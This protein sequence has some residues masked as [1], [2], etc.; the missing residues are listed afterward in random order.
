MKTSAIKNLALAV[1]GTS[2]I[3]VAPIA[4]AADWHRHDV[5]RPAEVIVKTPVLA[6][7]IGLGIGL[8]C[9][10]VFV[11]PRR[12]V[13]QPTVIVERDGWRHGRDW[14]HRR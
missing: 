6:I 2:L 10:H 11:A 12:V 13:C 14:D 4:S 5:I 1:I 9:E 8:A 3:A 7:G